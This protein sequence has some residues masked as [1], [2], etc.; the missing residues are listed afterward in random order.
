MLTCID[1]IFDYTTAPWQKVLEIS[2]HQRDRR[3]KSDA[4]RDSNDDEVDVDDDQHH[5]Q[6]CSI[7][8]RIANC[9]VHRIVVT[10]YKRSIVLVQKNKKKRS[11]RRRRNGWKKVI[12]SDPGEFKRGWLVLDAYGKIWGGVLCLIRI[13]LGFE[14]Y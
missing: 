1:L 12:Q 14:K 8:D 3:C 4:A 6:Q 10:I 7:S 5:F 2:S 9:F 13:P 11:S